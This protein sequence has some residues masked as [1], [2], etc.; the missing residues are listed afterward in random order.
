MQENTNKI[1]RLGRGRD[2][3]NLLKL[4]GFLGWWHRREQN[5]NKQK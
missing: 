4:Q 3:D 1:N 2:P 5:V